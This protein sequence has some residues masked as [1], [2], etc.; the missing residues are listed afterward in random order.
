MTSLIS[1]EKQLQLVDFIE[2]NT[3]ERL[4][5]L[6]SSSLQRSAMVNNISSVLPHNI[7]KAGNV[8]EEVEEQCELCN[9][10]VMILTMCVCTYAS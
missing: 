6:A 9:I 3:S 5:T 1:L 8:L 10:Q 2:K 7:A 4:Q